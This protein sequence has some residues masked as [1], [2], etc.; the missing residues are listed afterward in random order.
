[1]VYNIQNYWVI[2]LFPS[3]GILKTRR[4]NV[5]ETRSVSV[6]RWWRG[7]HL[8]SWVPKKELTSITGEIMSGLNSVQN[9]LFYISYLEHKD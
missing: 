8:L 6:L 1:M 5:Y 7:R 3:P 4:N 2:G 9:L